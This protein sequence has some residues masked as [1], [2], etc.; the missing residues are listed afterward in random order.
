MLIKILLVLWIAIMIITVAFFYVV[1]KKNK[2]LD[3][4]VLDE[5]ARK[6]PAPSNDIFWQPRICDFQHGPGNLQC[7][8]FG[9]CRPEERKCR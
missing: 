2:Q 4:A 1:G 5:L 9:A 7:S 6:R 8:I 3:Q